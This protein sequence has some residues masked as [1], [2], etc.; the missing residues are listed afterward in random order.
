MPAAVGNGHIDYDNDVTPQVV[1]MVNLKD[2]V[3]GQA[4]SSQAAFRVDGVEERWS[5]DSL[6][7]EHL[8][9]GKPRGNKRKGNSIGGDTQ[10][11]Y[12]KVTIYYGSTSTSLWRLTQI[13][14]EA[15]K[16]GWTVG[17]EGHGVQPEGRLLDGAECS[18][19]PGWWESV[20]LLWHGLQRTWF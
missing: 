10:A 16:A 18:N 14:R 17:E 6:L 20:C 4:Y 8:P 2:F 15:L 7:Q 13:W 1:G 12:S 9:E 11:G 19:I 3:N 5:V